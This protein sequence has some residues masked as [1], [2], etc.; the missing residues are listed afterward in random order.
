MFQS[1]VAG[2]KCFPL[3][4][5]PVK[6]FLCETDQS[7]IPE[8]LEMGRCFIFCRMTGPIYLHLR[9]VVLYTITII[10]IYI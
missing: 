10:Y 9:G 3:N 4:R 6:L 2:P 1:C 5:I 7:S 8:A